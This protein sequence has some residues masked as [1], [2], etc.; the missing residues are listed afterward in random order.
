MANNDYLSVFKDIDTWE[1]GSQLDTN[2]N[3]RGNW[4][5]G[6]I[7]RGTL[8]GTKHGVA[9][10]A[11]PTLDI[12]NIT[13]EQAAA[14][15]KHDYWDRICGDLLPGPVARVLA[16]CAYNQGVGAAVIILQQALNVAAD[17]ILGRQTL[18]AAAK[19]SNNPDALLIEI[20]ARRAYRYG[21]TSTFG[22]FGLGWSRRL[23]STVAKA[24]D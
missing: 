9:A 13:F 11:Y 18:A 5:S 2:P 10:F 20:A 15:F 4:T 12:A 3:D 22:T 17:G 1:G 7:G 14:I 16:D 21:T 6:V 24:L 19:Y 8:L 23:M